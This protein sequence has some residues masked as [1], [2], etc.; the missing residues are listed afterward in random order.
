MYM[1]VSRELLLSMPALYSIK[2]AEDFGSCKQ[3]FPLNHGAVNE[4]PLYAVFQLVT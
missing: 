2:G 4:V 3:R 1:N